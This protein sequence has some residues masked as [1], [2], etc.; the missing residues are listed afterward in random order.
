[1]KKLAILFSILVLALFIAPGLIGFKA[2][3]QYQEIVSGMERAGVEVISSEYKRGWFGS[4]A[5]TEFRLT[6][7][8]N[9]EA[10]EFKFSMQSD[11]VHGPLSTDGGLALASIGTSFKIDGK[12][13]FPEEGNKI[14]NTKIGLDGNGKTLITVPALKIAG[15]PGRPEL[16]FGG[17]DGELLF[18]VGFTQIDLELNIPEFWVGGADGESFRVTKVTLGSNSKSGLSNLQM[19]KAE[20]GIKQ[21][22]FVNPKNG[23]AV[24]K[25]GIRLIGDTREDGVNLVFGADYS[26]DAIAVNDASYGPA[27]LS[28]EI[29]N[30]PAAVAARIQQGMQQLRSQKLPEKQQAM[31]VMG[32]LL[33]VG[34]DILEA[35]PKLTIKRLF[36]K[37]PDGDIDGSLSIAA[38]GLLW[39]EIGD[40]QA[41]LD[42]LN[43]DASIRLPEKLLQSMLEA[44][45]KQSV[46]Q[47]IEMR[48]KMGE[49]VDMPS[50]EEIQ[51][52]GKSMVEQ[53]LGDLLQQGLLVRDEAYISSSAKLGGGLLSVNG[54][55]IPLRPSR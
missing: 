24:T 6:L 5:E 4:Q 25:L 17:A 45:A 16:Q 33:G 2:Q 42:K 29:E 8:P 34:P 10:N 27:E 44:Q 31:A 15:E 18:D 46:V 3:S 55:T 35:D 52:V 22:D 13:L 23:L 21:I 9:V 19:G 51:T 20:L 37:T 26:V 28:V 32:L 12:T 43:A 7:P 53:R 14:L 47:N 39:K 38:D 41:M 11:I 30:I 50:P 40:V 48:K 49:S 1:M 54:K 36:I